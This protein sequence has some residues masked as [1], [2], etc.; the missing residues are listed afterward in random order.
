MKYFE[1][2]E[3]YYAL[4][5]SEDKE[6]AMKFYINVVADDEEGTLAEEIKEVDRQYAWGCFLKGIN[7]DKNISSRSVLKHSFDRNTEELL[8][9]DGALL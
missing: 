3:P 4:I 9:I 6:K 5:K 7:E 2:Q 8:L 1:V